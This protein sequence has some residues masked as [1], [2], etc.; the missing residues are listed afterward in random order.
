MVPIKKLDDGGI[1]WHVEI[2]AQR[3]SILQISQVECLRK[4][5]YKTLDLS[6]LLDAPALLGWAASGSLH[7]GTVY[8]P[9]WLG[10]SQAT[11]KLG[12]WTK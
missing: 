5:W 1:V 7:L 2:N 11:Y 9:K 6:S 4:P 10:P 8:P 12:N 3:T